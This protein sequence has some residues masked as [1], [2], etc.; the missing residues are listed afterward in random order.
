M[1]SDDSQCRPSGT[2]AS[3]S[4]VH[5]GHA[6]MVDVSEK[7]VSLRAAEAE[8]RVRLGA[9][10]AARLRE[11]GE[12]GKGNV[13]ETARMA[14]IAGAKKCSELIPMCHPLPL[15]VVEIA[16]ELVEQTV[17]LRSR[18]VCHARTGVEMEALTAV[19]VAALTVYDMVKAADKQI[20]IGPIRLVSKMGGKS[21]EWRREQ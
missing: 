12:A 15:D 20:E 3:L 16:A 9:A 1:P 19:T 8:A 4:H 13:L 21:G 10:T 17:L 5:E 7:P 2:G 18:V 6:V 11:T 14:G